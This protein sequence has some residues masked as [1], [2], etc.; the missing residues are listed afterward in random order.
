MAFGSIAAFDSCS[1]SRRLRLVCWRFIARR[2]GCLNVTAAVTS[3]KCSQDVV[4]CPRRTLVA[5]S[6]VQHD[7]NH[8]SLLVRSVYSPSTAAGAVAA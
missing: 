2:L 8:S 6:A 1:F 7:L 4:F 3:W 5:A